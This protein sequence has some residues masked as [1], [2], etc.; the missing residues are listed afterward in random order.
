MEERRKIENSSF[1][2]SEYSYNKATY[3]VMPW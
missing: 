2:L 3:V 1:P